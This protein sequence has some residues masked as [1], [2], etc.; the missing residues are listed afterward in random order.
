MIKKPKISVIIPIYNVEKYID[1][2]IDSVRNQTFQNIEILCVDDCSPD[3]SYRI[4]EKHAAEDSRIRLIRHTKNLGLGGARNTALRVAT[5]EYIASVDSD[6][7]MLPNMLQRLWEE[8]DNGW[9]DIVSCGFNRVDGNGNIISFQSYPATTF[10]NEENDINIFA[11]VNPAFWNKLWRKSLFT[12]NDIF[13]PLHLYFEDMSTTPRIFA[14]ATY[15]KVIEERLY[16]YFIRQ[17]SI[18]TSYSA[19]HIIDYYQGFE[20]LLRFLENNRIL[21]RYKDEFIEYVNSNMRFHSDNVVGS[22]MPKADLEQY[23]RHMLMFKIAFLENRDLLKYKNL[24]DLLML[25]VQKKVPSALELKKNEITEV[26]KEKNRVKEEYQNLLVSKEKD[27]SKYQELLNVKEQEASK[28]QGLL[29]DKEQEISS[30]QLE[31]DASE[32]SKSSILKELSEFKRLLDLSREDKE[33][34]ENEVLDQTKRLVDLEKNRDAIQVEMSKYLE[35]TKMLEQ[36]KAD[37]ILCFQKIG[38]IVFGVFIRLSCTKKQ[39][40]KLKLTPR[41]FFKDSKNTVTRFIGSLLGV[42]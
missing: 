20:I 6:D 18:T 37:D 21:D 15:I 19:K 7:F 33:Y 1:R 3:N 9:F 2:C 31:I 36:E 41:Q 17:E 26:E 25:L 32:Q 35:K 16:Q 27:A 39:F 13:F 42:I 10:L 24:G 14:K 22:D 34:L 30:I 11:T 28:L 29:I 8:T 4:V 12:E 38:V 40:E 23:L 5:A